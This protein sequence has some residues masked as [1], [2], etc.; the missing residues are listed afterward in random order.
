MLCALSNGCND[1]VLVSIPFNLYAIDTLVI[2]DGESCC[3]VSKSTV[4]R[5]VGEEQ[6]IAIDRQRN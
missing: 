2:V 4:N 3:S 1:K 5:E 6:L